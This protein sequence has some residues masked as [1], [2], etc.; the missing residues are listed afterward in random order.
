MPVTSLPRLGV[1][2]LFLEGLDNT[3]LGFVG[4]QAKWKTLCKNL[5]NHLKC[6]QL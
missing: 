5:Y 1:G 3:N 4:Q 2:K 6:N